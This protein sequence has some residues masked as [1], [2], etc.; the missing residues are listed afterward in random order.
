LMSF[1]IPMTLAYDKV[2]SYDT[3]STLPAGGSQKKDILSR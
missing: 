3:I 2:V 1:L